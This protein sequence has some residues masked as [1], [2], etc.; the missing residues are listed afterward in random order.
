MSE[1]RITLLSVHQL[2]KR[3]HDEQNKPEFTPEEQ[4]YIHTQIR[5]EYAKAMTSIAAKLE[6]AY[7]NARSRVLLWAHNYP[8]AQTD[9]SVFR[10]VIYNIRLE[11]ERAGYKPD[12]VDVDGG[13]VT[14]TIS[15]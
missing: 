13:Y 4:E 12:I 7:T 15:F 3:I 8:I 1:D 14:I 6:F 9:I 2:K 10:K 11:L 5:V